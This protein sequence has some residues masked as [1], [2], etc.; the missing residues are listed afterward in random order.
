LLTWILFLCLVTLT[1]GLSI[2]LIFSKNQFLVLL[3]HSIVLFV[4]T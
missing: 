3:I 2:M 4:S 1:N